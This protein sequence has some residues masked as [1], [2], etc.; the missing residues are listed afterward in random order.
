MTIDWSKVPE[1]CTHFDPVDMN[2]LRQS[3]R[4]SEAW[5]ATNKCW[6]PVGWQYPKD[7]STMARLIKRPKPWTCEGLPPVGMVCEWMHHQAPSVGDSEW[8]VGDIRYISD[9]TVIIGGEGC[10]HVHHPRNLSF[11][12][13]RTAEQIAAEERETAIDR[14]IDDTNIL[15]GIMSDRRIMAGQLYDAGYRKQEQK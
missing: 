13:V 3:V 4:S 14:M 5:S 11:R 2:H 7:L 15:T 10:E 6:E 12:P 8:H 9:C 1:G